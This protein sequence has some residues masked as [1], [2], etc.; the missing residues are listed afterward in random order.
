MDSLAAEGTVLSQSVAANVEVDVN[1][2]IVL[3]YSTGKDP[4]PPT[5]PSDPSVPGETSIE[6]TFI[7]P[8]AAESYPLRIEME[9]EVVLA[10]TV[11]EPGHTELTLTL[12]GSGTMNCTLYINGEIYETIAVNFE[13]DE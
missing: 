6:Q 10:D 13:A 1:T 3:E 8:S 11:I 9:G 4:N 12:T 5:D 2:L 7:L